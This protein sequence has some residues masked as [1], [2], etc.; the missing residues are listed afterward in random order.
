MIASILCVQRG[1]NCQFPGR[2]V[3]QRA[4]GGAVHALLKM[5]DALAALL[6]LATFESVQESLFY[7]MVP[8]LTEKLRRGKESPEA[9]AGGMLA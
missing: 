5:S 3:G 6:V 2:R 8:L 7:G 1:V 4:V 9:E